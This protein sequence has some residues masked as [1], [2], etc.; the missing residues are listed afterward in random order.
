MPL[1]TPPLTLYKY[2]PD[3]IDFFDSPCLR[4]TPINELNDPF[5]CRFTVNKD[6]NTTFLSSALE[7]LPRLVNSFTD[8]GI[9][10][11]SSSNDNLLMW[12]HYTKNHSGFV[13]G[14][15]TEHEFLRGVDK[16]N[17][18]NERLHFCSDELF[19][20][21]KASF[22]YRNTFYKSLAWEYEEEWRLFRVFISQMV[23]L[24]PHVKGLVECPA[25]LIQQIF[26]GL[27]ASDDLKKAA[28]SYCM[29]HPSAS[30]YQANLHQSR[31]ALEFVPIEVKSL[32]SSDIE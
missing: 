7:M 31:Y 30:L 21:K 14:M 24:K 17:Y 23:P 15:D 18:T 2:L 29:M 6:K 19:K 9:L 3:R 4:F 11:L 27:N 26:L 12:A 10:S 16:V 25:D 32:S 8:T 20:T 28:I 22:L 5:E 13:I 1:N